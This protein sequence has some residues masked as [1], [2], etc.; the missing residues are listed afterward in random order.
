MILQEDAETFK[1]FREYFEDTV[2][3][4]ELANKLRKKKG[5]ISREESR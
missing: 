1:L 3:Q 4:I 5:T 2:D